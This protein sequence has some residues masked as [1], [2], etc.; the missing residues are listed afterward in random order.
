MT[1]R[2]SIALEKQGA[3]K[4]PTS[5]HK[6][7]PAS[8]GSRVPNSIRVR[9]LPIYPVKPLL[10]KSQRQVCGFIL[11]RHHS[12]DSGQFRLIPRGSP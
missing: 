1:A 12:R 2:R 5:A 10:Y 3:R 9:H 7:D 4:G 6:Q 8:E 11:Q